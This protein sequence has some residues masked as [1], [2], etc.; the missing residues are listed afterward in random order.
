MFIQV[1]HLQQ[2]DMLDFTRDIGGSAIAGNEENLD[3]F[4]F[5][6]SC[7][8]GEAGVAIAPIPPRLAPQSRLGLG[9]AMHRILARYDD[10]LSFYRLEQQFRER[11]GILIPRQQM[12]QWAEHI[13]SWLRPIYDAM[14]E[15]M[16][17]GG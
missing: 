15:L 7:R 4:C 2:N 6:I 3:R 13:A 8:C 10:H 17:A 14:W 1:G 12:V 16:V 11:H 9:L 5:R